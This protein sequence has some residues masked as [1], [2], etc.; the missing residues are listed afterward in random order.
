MENWKDILEYEGLY[1]VSDLGNI[2]SFETKKN[3]LLHLDS[4]GYLRLSLTKD[5]KRKTKKVHQLV[6]IAFLNHNPSDK[7]YVVDH[8]NN[9]K[10]DNRLVNLQLISQ[11]ENVSKDK[12]KTTSKYT[13]VCWD[14]QKMKFK[15]SI[16]INS[17]SK[18]LG[19]F[20]CQIE[21]SNAYQKA[22]KNLT[23]P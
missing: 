18:H 12:T 1:Q 13:G 9:I 3:R 14:K 7:K 8:I 15:A 11:R 22:L 17:K 5:N 19:M 21:A 6:A 20:N 2:R 23:K 4:Y 10:T 16:R